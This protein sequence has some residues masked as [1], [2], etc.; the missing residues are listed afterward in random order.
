MAT[1]YRVQGGRLAFA[2]GLWTKSKPPKSDA[3]AKEKYRATIL[4]PKD[5]PQIP[6]IIAIM[7]AE[8]K[9]TFGAKWEAVYKAAEMQQ[10]LCLRDGD[11]K[12]QYAGFEGWYYISASSE[13]QPSVYGYNPNDGIIQRDSGKVFS[14]CWVN[15]S[16]DFYAY[17]SVAKGVAAG[18]RG[19]QLCLT[20]PGMPDDALGGGTAASE[21]DFEPIGVKAEADPLL[22]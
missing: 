16:L 22:A 18:L 4:L 5:H 10:K 14:G 13:I 17:D 6:E 12:S 7:K 3:S 19:V 15:A 20:P 21:S 2:Q 11:L 1:R 9:A 8:A